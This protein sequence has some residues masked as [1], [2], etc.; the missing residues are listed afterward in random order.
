MTELSEFQLRQRDKLYEDFEKECIRVLHMTS[1]EVRNVFL[2]FDDDMFDEFNDAFF[3]GG[4]PQMWY[5]MMFRICALSVLY[6]QRELPEDAPW[7][8]LYDHSRTIGID[9]E[10]LYCE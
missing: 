1:N 2:K 6:K 3:E 10:E 9:L 8:D 7:L 5:K 4:K